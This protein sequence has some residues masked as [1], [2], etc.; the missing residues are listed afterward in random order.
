MSQPQQPPQQPPQHPPQEWAPAMIP[1]MFI[2][3]DITFGLW[4]FATGRVPLE[5]MTVLGQWILALSIPLLMLGMVD[6]R[7][8]DI[9]GATLNMVFGGILGLGTGFSF[10]RT[11]WQPFVPMTLDGY[12]LLMGAVILLVLVSVSIKFSKLMAIFMVEISIALFAISFASI[13]FISEPLG[14]MIG[15]WLAL[16]FSMFAIYAALANILMFVNKKPVLPFF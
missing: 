1:S 14:F 4:A 3:G 7:R 5:M 10:M 15:G 12:F 8:G 2:I 13:G 9:L 6:M 16:F 11:L